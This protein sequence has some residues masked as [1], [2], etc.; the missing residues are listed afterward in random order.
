[1]ATRELHVLPSYAAQLRLREEDGRW[2]YSFDGGVP[3]LLLETSEGEG[4]EEGRRGSQRR[5]QRDGG[6]FGKKKKALDPNSDEGLI[7]AELAK[8]KAQGKADLKQIEQLAKG[9]KAAENDEWAV[10]RET[11]G[12]Y[13]YL[14]FW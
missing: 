6:F 10:G 14:Y 3:T 9:V 13:Y 1:M 12:R 11:S 4:E 5:R 7:Q 2:G 8:E